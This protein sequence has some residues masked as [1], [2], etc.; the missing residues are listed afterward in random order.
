MNSALGRLLLLGLLLLAMLAVLLWPGGF[1]LQSV[2]DWLEGQP[3]LGPLLWVVL[4][5]IGTVLA[6]PGLLLTLAGGALFGP[7]LG[8]A[9]NLLGA[10]LGSSG[11]FMIARYLG[12]DWLEARMGTRLRG[13]KRSI[14]AEG[15]R[16]VAFLRLV[17]IFP[18]NLINYALGL[19][20]IPLGQYALV[21]LLCMAPATAAY[22]WI[23]VVGR[24]AVAGEQ[25]LLQNGL[26]A[27]ALLASVMLLPRMVASLRRGA[28]VSVGQ[29]R[30][31]LQQPEP[32][33]LLDVRSEEELHGE[34]GHLPGITHIPLNELNARI[35]ELGDWMEQPVLIL[36][37]TDVRSAKAARQLAARGFAD[38]HVVSGGM[39]AWNAEGWPVEH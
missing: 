14:E 31:R 11:A 36:C 24:N 17:P 34:L 7:W 29:L 28:T 2:V 6:V 20:R 38:V 8:T 26:I 39:S 15:W 25:D 4:Y 13:L 35:D 10:V 18:F 33:L 23:G 22:T 30:E 12:A 27:L 37:R 1:P 9:V 16:F 3:L 21:S 32:Q 19:T 5:A